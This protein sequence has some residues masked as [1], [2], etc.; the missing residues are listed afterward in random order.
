MSVYGRRK[1]ILGFHG[2]PSGVRGREALHL[3]INLELSLQI[4]GSFT[5]ELCDAQT[6]AP[7][8]IAQQGDGDIQVVVTVLNNGVPQ[9][10]SAAHDLAILI[11]KPDSTIVSYPATQMTNG[12]DGK[13]YVA[14][15]PAD[16]ED[17]GYYTVQASFTIATVQKSTDQGD[18]IV[19][20]VLVVTPPIVEPEF[21][22]S[23]PPEQ[24]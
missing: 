2:C 8:Q 15:S 16:L 9:D 23:D 20:E 10:M 14:L 21:E 6:V 11:K 13:I 3:M 4:A 18:F 19:G 5:G 12:R 22:N 1:T 24:D 17:A 7:D